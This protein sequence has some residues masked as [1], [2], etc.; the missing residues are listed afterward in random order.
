MLPLV[1]AGVLFED[2]TPVGEENDPP[3]RVLEGGE[4]QERVLM[5]A[6]RRL[7]SLGRLRELPVG[8]LK[9]H[10]ACCAACRTT[11]APACRPAR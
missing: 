2:G 9:L 5:C 4:P 7:K 6:R 11:R 10:P 3:A 1:E 8:E